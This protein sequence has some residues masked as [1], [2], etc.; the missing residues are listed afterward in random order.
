M[1]IRTIGIGILLLLSSVALVIAQA[2]RDLLRDCRIKD[3]VDGDPAAA[4][5][6]CLRVVSDF[7]SDRALVADARLY[8]GQLYATK[9]PA[10]AKEQYD[11]VAA[12]S[13][14]PAR[15]ADARTR[16]A[17]LSVDP[18]PR[19]EI[20]TPFTDDPFSFAIS[21]DG[22][23]LVYQSTEGGKSQLWLWHLDTRKASPIP[24]TENARQWALP[25]WSPDGKNI[26]FFAEQKLKTIP[27]EGGVARNLFGPIADPRGGTW[28]SDDVIVFS[29]NV[30][31]LYRVN[32]A[33]GESAIATPQGDAQ[34][35]VFPRF[36]ADGRNFIYWK[37]NGAAFYTTVA[38]L[39]DSTQRPLSSG[40]GAVQVLPDHLYFARAGAGI[41]VGVLSDQP[42]SFQKLEASGSS[43]TLGESV[44]LDRRYP[45]LA[46]LSASAR[47]PV[48]YRTDAAVNRR[49]LW[50]DRAGQEQGNLGPPDESSPCCMRFSNDAEVV[51]F[52]RSV[53]HGTGSMWLMDT[54]TGERVRFR[55]GIRNLVFSPKG[56]EIAW[57]GFPNLSSLNTALFRQ[58][59][60]VLKGPGTAI[61]TGTNTTQ[62]YAE[63]WSGNDYILYRRF[64]ATTAN[65]L[66]A[67]SVKGSDPI[68]VA[69]GPADQ[70][71]GRFSP[72][73]RW[74]T[75]QSDEIGGRY[76]VYVQPFGA[77]AESRRA[78][79]IGGGTIPQ[80]SRDGRQLYFLSADDHV[81]VVDVTLGNEI[82]LSTPRPLFPKALRHGSTFEFTPD[83]QRILVNTPTE[84]PAPIVLLPNG[85]K[86][87]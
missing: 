77:L 80:W 52:Y 27:A 33:D 71:N 55:D 64:G 50:L 21:P 6:I 72:D 59:V 14:Q 22:K 11:L 37:V 75:Y 85:P 46:A 34:Q 13:D 69:T 8:L 65:D 9:E 28:N 16:L 25:F 20:P 70:R 10:K 32:L 62:A 43:I 39:E 47:G 7:P 44:G 82:E 67:M 29:Q 83:G 48:A 2:G 61:I 58:P 54:G 24:G 30:G 79:S 87:P 78:V 74:V 73:A 1:R 15:A 45:G 23:S 81:M 5:K 42:L 17:A 4:I 57:N 66:L 49:F 84:D 60:N 31:P 38:S 3:Q 36:S 51:A 18:Y 26:G 53:D 35:N 19:I 63:D 56:D 86:R 12:M 40:P 68:P 76:E 41:D